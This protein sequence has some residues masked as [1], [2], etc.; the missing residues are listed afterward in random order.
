MGNEKKSGN[1]LIFCIRCIFPLSL[2]NQNRFNKRV[3]DG[4]ILEIHKREESM[5]EVWTVDK[6][7][8]KWI[9]GEENYSMQKT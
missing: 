4:I 5:C 6:K 9:K 7:N 3:N 2:R 1:F 8:P